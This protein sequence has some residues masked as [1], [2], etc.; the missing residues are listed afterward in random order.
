MMIALGIA[1][2]AVL[3][4][5]YL[6]RLEEHRVIWLAFASFVAGLILLAYSVNPD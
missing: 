6:A 1:L 3:P 2:T 5:C 4:I